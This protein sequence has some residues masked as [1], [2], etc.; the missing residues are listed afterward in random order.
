MLLTDNV[1]DL[2]YML[3]YRIYSKDLKFTV[4]NGFTINVDKI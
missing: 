1:F 4:Q 3:K 2:K